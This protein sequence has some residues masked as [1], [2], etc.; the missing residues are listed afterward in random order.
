MM[1]S[2]GCLMGTHMPVKRSAGQLLFDPF[3]D[4]LIYRPK[5]IVPIVFIPSCLWRPHREPVQRCYDTY[6]GK[7][8]FAG[9]MDVMRRKGVATMTWIVRIVFPTAGMVVR[10]D[11]ARRG[12]H[13]GDLL[14]CEGDLGWFALLVEDHRS[15]LIDS[16]GRLKEVWEI[17]R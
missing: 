8:R 6:L 15:V 1:P 2:C 14:V 9:K 10:E 17:G 3:V 11:D 4:M 16:K 5:R 7:F 12:L 13:P